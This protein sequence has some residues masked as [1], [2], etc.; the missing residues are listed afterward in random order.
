[1]MSLVT[2]E[3]LVM[4]RIVAAHG[5]TLG[6]TSQVEPVIESQVVF[7]SLPEQRH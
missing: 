7:V 2:L 4:M 5:V 1:M 6:V 3:S